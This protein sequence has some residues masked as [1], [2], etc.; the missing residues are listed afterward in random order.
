MKK[1]NTKQRLWH[2]IDVHLQQL[3]HGPQESVLWLHLLHSA[4]SKTTDEFTTD[5]F[6][7]LYSCEDVTAEILRQ[8]RTRGQGG[9]PVSDVSEHDKVR[10]RITGSG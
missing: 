9:M 5:E 10:V 1:K 6:H 3:S 8:V 4:L 2:S 7:P